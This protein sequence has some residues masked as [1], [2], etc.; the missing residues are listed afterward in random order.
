[1]R[2]PSIDLLAERAA[3]VLR[4]FSWTLAAGLTA[5]VAAIIASTDGAD[6]LA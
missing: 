2:F 5:A 4:R 3:L 1:M 6:V